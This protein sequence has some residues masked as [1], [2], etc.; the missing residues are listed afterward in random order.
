MA[1]HNASMS[2]LMKQLVTEFLTVENASSIDIHRK[3]K[4]V[5][6]EKYTESNKIQ[7]L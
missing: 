2:L 7:G 3:M 1:L 4:G 5:Y 6:G